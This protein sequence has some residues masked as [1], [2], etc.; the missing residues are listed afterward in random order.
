L[1]TPRPISKDSE[2]VIKALRWQTQCER[3]ATLLGQLSAA[4]LG[5]SE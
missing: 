5:G 4:N 3:V 1:R 2:I